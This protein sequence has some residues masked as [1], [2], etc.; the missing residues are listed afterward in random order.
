MTDPSS[1]PAVALNGATFL[2]EGGRGVHDVTLSLA[3]GTILGLLGPN[4]SGKSTILSMVAGFRTPASGSVRVLGAH[5]TSQARAR[6]GLLFQESSLD[7]LMTVQETLWLHGRLFG[8]GGGALRARSRELLRLVGLDDRH[9]DAVETLSGGLKRR[10]ELA[11]C[12]LHRPTLLLLDEPTIAL[13]PDSRVQL[14]D[15]LQAVNAEGAA[16]LLATNDVAEAERYCHTVAFLD[17]GRLVRE[18]APADLKRNLRRDSVRIDWPQPP[19]DIDGALMGWDGVGGVTWAPPMLH[20]TV[21]DASTFVP[22]LF[23]VSGGGI[24][25]LRIHEST[26]EDAY[27]QLVGA[28]FSPNGAAGG[29]DP[30]E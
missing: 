28:P 9:H 24:R 22:A 4:G 6:M 19:P 10:L 18:G 29:T 27:F 23:A 16:L 7:P 25:G 20:V 12:L 21:D 13:D 8:L 1:Q 2:Y 3:P 30:P 11:R 15:L 17:R 14:W 5:L 26:L